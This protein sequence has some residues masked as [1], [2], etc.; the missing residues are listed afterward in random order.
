[1]MAGIGG[2]L[3]AGGLSWFG[4]GLLED[5]PATT[6]NT[7][8]PVS[9]AVERRSA[10]S[11]AQPTA[12]GAAP[13]PS[14]PVDDAPKV[15]GSFADRD[16]SY[17]RA[18][19]PEEAYTG[20]AGLAASPKVAA[21]EVAQAENVVKTPLTGESKLHLLRR[22]TF[23]PTPADVAEVEKL[24]IDDWIERQLRPEELDDP[25]ADRVLEKFPLVSMTTAELLAT[26]ERFSW[27]AMVEVRDA[28]LA[29]QLWSKRQLLE[30]MVEFWHNHL[31]VPIPGDSWDT[32]VFHDREVIRKHA[33]GKFADL[34]RASAR[35]PS[36]LWYLSNALSNRESV[37]EN[38]GREVLEL[39]TVGIDGGYNE[40]DVRNSAY[41]LSGRTAT[42]EG[43]F[44]YDPA[45]HWV[46]EV[47]ALGFSDAN[48]SPDEGLAVGDRYLDHLARLP[49]TARR[50]AGKL[51]V[52]FVS[53][54]PPQSLVDRLAQA[55]LDNDTAIVPV[56]RVLF[57]SL[58]FW[59]APGQKLRRPG[60]N[61]TATARVL[62]VLPGDATGKGL[63]SF[64]VWDMGPL[65]QAPLGWTSPDG[66]PDVAGAWRS[67]HIT[68]GQWNAH[69]VLVH[70]HRPGLTF[71]KPESLVE[72]PPATTGE[73]LDAL[74]RRLL[75]QPLRAS[76]R[77]ALLDY[78][79]AKDDAPVGEPPL[80]GHI[81]EVAALMLDSINHSLR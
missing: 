22:L 50:I 58:E 56:L 72:D 65:G 20:P 11:A 5:E 81:A 48:A 15:A 47:H 53:D 62:D 6:E 52:R 7:A 33:L 24:G 39:H 8:Q 69:R 78:L 26:I 80:G 68:L 44:H 51:A 9:D 32:A 70:G 57:R 34:L 18:V 14:R 63:E 35:S 43:E 60:E 28:T 13:L 19:A 74:A 66:Y 27:S 79:E 3:A 75:F 21:E 31:H 76:E 59:A 23:G 42:W 64:S 17:S 46:G 10:P 77:Q 41:I 37:N 2:L 67:T 54:N 29:R 40:E 4:K 61:Y 30:V 55:Y 16:T 25:I 73:Y 12:P 49:A 71:R 38:Y 1:M 45:K 36:M